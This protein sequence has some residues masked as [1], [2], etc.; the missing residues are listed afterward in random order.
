MEY[1][2]IYPTG[3]Q[4]SKL[5]GMTKVQKPN[6]LLRPVLSAINIP[7]YGMTKWIENQLRPLL[8]DKH[9]TLSSKEFIEKV[10]SIKPE[11]TNFMTS[12]DIKSLYTQVPVKEVINDI[13]NTVYERDN[14]KSIFQN[15][16]ITKTV[17]KNMLNLCSNAVFLYNNKVLQQTDGV[18]MG[19]PL[20]PLL[21]NWFV[22]RQEEEI[23][24]IQNITPKF[25]IRYVDDIFTIFDSEM[26]CDNFYTEMNNI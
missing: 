10:T 17:L 8:K 20:A 13:L 2:K 23:L 14:N 24:K 11:K 4:P 15:S 12:F 7:E 6:C 1:K 22:C 26:K 3:S 5:Y 21:A 16:S 25:Y 19:S 18:A 9:S